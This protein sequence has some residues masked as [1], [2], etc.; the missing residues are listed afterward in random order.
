MPWCPSET[1]KKGK[2]IIQVLIA[3]RNRDA[4]MQVLINY[5]PYIPKLIQIQVPKQK[6]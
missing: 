2:A 1:V 3:L 6:R 5:Y 4:A